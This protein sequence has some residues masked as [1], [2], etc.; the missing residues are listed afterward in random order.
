[1]YRLLRPL[2]WN[3]SPETAH[4]IAV[5]LIKHGILNLYSCSLDKRLKV[6]VAGMDFASPVGMAAGFDKNAEIYN[7]LFKI[8]FGFVEV[9]TVTPRPQYGNIKPRIF[10]LQDDLGLINRLG[11][12]NV[13]LTQF[14][15]NFDENNRDLESQRRV[16]INIGPNKDSKDRIKDFVD[17]LKEAEKKADYI[18][19]NISSPNTPDLRDFESSK[20]V[21]LLSEIKINRET[22]T[23]IFVK[24]S[25]DLENSRISFVIET[26]LKNNLSGLIVSNTS[27]SRDF[28]LKSSTSVQEGGLSGHP[29]LNL[30]NQ[31]L[32]F[33]YSVTKGLIPLVGV[34]G[35]SSGADVYKKIKL[36]ANLVELYTSMIFEGPSLISAINKE[37][38]YLMRIEG[39]NNLSEVVGS[40]K[41]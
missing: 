18:T 40:I 37:L 5:V 2:I 23:P 1:M 36:G 17:C 8:G 38:L 27:S 7:Q 14:I 22:K 25:P 12:N 28:K 33:A 10:R 20:I 11:F 3:L 34:G 6:E 9:G 35:I 24:V 41:E 19:V 13:G 21:E 15:S 30:S 32:A 39:I 4:N 29:I 16:G 26:I 31:K